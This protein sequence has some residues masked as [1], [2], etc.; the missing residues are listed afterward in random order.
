[1]N[2]GNLPYDPESKWQSAI[3]GVS[4]NWLLLHNIV[5]STARWHLQKILGISRIA[6]FE[7]VEHFFD[8]MVSFCRKK[9]NKCDGVHYI[10]SNALRSI[11]LVKIFI[12]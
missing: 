3:W 12:L 8:N 10:I 11:H 9:Q 1:M 6:I 2:P 4:N 7:N 5:P